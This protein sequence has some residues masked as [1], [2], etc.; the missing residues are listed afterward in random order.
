[1]T[2]IQKGEE[3]ENKVKSENFKLMVQTVLMIL[4]SGLISF[5]FFM[6]LD[7]NPP[8][9]IQQAQAGV[10]VGGNTDKIPAGP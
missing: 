4:I 8:G 6:T 7:N 10:D 1:M 5:M 3:Y 2:K 9:Y